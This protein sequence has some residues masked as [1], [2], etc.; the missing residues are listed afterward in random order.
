MSNFLQNVKKAST[1]KMQNLFSQGGSESFNEMLK[2]ILG[3]RYSHKSEHSTKN[4]YG[5]M[6]KQ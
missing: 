3:I 4:V 2:G 1:K 5:G 6:P